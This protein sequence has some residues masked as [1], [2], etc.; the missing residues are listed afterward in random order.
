MEIEDQ[1][2]VLRR[3][4]YEYRTCKLNWMRHM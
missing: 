4:I 3:H 2:T 1:I